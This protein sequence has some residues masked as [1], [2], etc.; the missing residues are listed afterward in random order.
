VTLTVPNHLFRIPA[1]AEDHEVTAAYTFDQDV[2]LINYM[3]HM[4]LRGKDMKYE[5]IYPGG[6]RETLLWVPRFNFNWQTLYSLTDPIAI[7]KGTRLIVTAH[8]DNS[9]KNKY[10]P[11]P[12]KP[13]RWGDPTYDE[14]MIGWVDYVAQNPDRPDAALKGVR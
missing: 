2:Q 10:N 3:P 5:V 9:A 11:D 13:V 14:M 4:H 7:P 12:N 8:F 1:G 6:K